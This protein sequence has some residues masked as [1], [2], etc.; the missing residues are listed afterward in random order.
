MEVKATLNSTFLLICRVMLSSMVGPLQGG[1][2]HSL[3]PGVLALGETPSLGCGS[4]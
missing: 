4:T 2:Q 3:P 1:P